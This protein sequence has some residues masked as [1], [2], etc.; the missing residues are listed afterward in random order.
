MSW[1]KAEQI[2]MA[3]DLLLHYDMGQLLSVY[4]TEL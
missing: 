4:W 3:K 2:G 1:R